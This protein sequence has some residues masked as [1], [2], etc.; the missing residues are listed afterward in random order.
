MNETKDLQKVGI[1]TKRNIIEVTK[2]AN[3]LKAVVK[4]LKEQGKEIYFDNNSARLYKNKEGYKKE[5]LM[6][7]VDLCIT[8][9]GDG[10]ILKTARRVS[11]K[12]VIVFGINLGTLGFLTECN[13]DKIF[14]CLK[15]ILEGNYA[16]DKRSLLRVTVYRKGEKLK[17]FLA[18]NDAVI[19]QG[20][21]ARLITLDLE[22]NGRKMVK[23]KADGLIVAT[24]TGSTAHSLSAGGPIVHPMIEGLIITPICPTSLSMR[25]ILL[26]GSRLIT[27]T[28]ETQRRDDEAIIGLTI[29]GQDLVMLKYGDQ[30]K[31]RRSRRNLYFARTRHQYYKILRN[32]LNWGEANVKD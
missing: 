16:V 19:N 21:F 31:V 8:L 17:T 20:A 26:P 32:K 30:V 18:L 24:P 5:E 9:G 27:I 1:I 23:F 22:I 12:K 25:S 29:D 10:T 13:P 2:N 15:K 3:V 11:Y 4:Y 28:V 14:E 6:K 7:K